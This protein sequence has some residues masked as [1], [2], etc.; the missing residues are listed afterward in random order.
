MAELSPLR[1]RIIEDMTVRNLSPATQRSYLH[2]VSK[3]SRFFNRSPDRLDLEDV[4]T[5][6]VHL[7]SQGISWASLNQFV[8]ALR[9]FYGVTL[10]CPEIPERITYA[11]QPRRLPVVLSADEVVRFLEA[12]PS[13]KNRTALRGRAPKGKRLRASAPFGH[14]KTETFIAG[15]RSEPTFQDNEA[16]SQRADCRQISRRSDW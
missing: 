8:A 13:L 3:F 2:A 12:V 4:R 5:W 9:F 15:L 14:W 1:R 6:Q 11:R 10:R 16:S 7:V